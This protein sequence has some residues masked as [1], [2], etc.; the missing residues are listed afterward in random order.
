MVVIPYVAV[1]SGD[2]RQVRSRLGKRA[3]SIYVWSNT[4][5]D[6]DQSEGHLAVRKAIRVVYKISCSCGQV[7]MERP[8]GD[9][10]PE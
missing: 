7:Y 5:A 9:W 10:K 8:S 1:V 4:L 3:R 6:V 2:I